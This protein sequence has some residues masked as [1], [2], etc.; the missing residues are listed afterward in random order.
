MG[1]FHRGGPLLTCVNVVSAGLHCMLLLIQV[2]LL[3]SSWYWPREQ[4]S[5]L[6]TVVAALR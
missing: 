4:K 5:T 1:T 3:G 6:W 2:T